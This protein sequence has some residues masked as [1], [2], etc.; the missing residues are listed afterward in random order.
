MEVTTTLWAT[1]SGE[2]GHKGTCALHMYSSKQRRPSHRQAQ[3]QRP[4]VKRTS[5]SLQHMRMS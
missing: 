2:V 1:L 4:C 3:E 5:P